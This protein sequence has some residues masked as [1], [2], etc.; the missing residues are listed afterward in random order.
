MFKAFYDK[1][2]KLLAVFLFEN[3]ENLFEVHLKM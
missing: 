2:I 3:L 1:Y